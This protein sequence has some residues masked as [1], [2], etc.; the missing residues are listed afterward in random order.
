MNRRDFKR[1]KRHDNDIKLH[2]KRHDNVIKLRRKRHDDDIKLRRKRH[3][4]DIKLRRKR[5][6][7]D[8]KLCRKQ[9]DNEMCRDKKRQVKGSLLLFKEPKPRWQDAVLVR[10]R[11]KELHTVKEGSKNGNM[12]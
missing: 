12:F 1:R 7:S 2:R 8:I 9:H 5:Y 10:L 4:N 3:D 11:S 6:D